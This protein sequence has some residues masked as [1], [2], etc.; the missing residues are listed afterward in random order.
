MPIVMKP[1]SVAFPCASGIDAKTWKPTKLMR[2]NPMTSSCRRN[3]SWGIYGHANDLTYEITAHA[4]SSVKTR[5]MNEAMAV[6][7]LPFLRIQNNSPSV[8]TAC[9][10]LSVKFLGNGPLKVSGLISEPRPLPSMPWQVRQ[11]PFPSKIRLP[12]SIISGVEGYGFVTLLALSICST[13]T[14]GLNTVGSAGQT[15]EDI[16]A[17]KKGVAIRSAVTHTLHL[18]SDKGRRG[19]QQDQCLLLALA[20][21][22]F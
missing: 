13:G 7:L 5:G 22:S 8:R 19:K 9:Q 20:C 11:N 6:P 14:R 16:I 4:S 17:I 1:I 3:C 15:A 21:L 18:P 10:S 12:C 2:H